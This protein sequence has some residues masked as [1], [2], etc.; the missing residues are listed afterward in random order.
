MFPYKCKNAKAEIKGS[1]KYSSIRGLVLF[2]E[3][4]KGILVTANIEGLPKSQGRCK[5]NFFG[6]H[7]HTGTLCTGNKEDEFDD[8]LTHYNPNDCIHPYH[9]GD[10]PQLLEND[11]NAY[12]SILVNKFK[13]SEIVGKVIII[14]DKPDD[15]TT[16]PSGNSG[17]KIACGVIKYC[18]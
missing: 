15:F 11:G 17:N 5:G 18:K 3:T 6:F 4:N 10:L 7:I 8:A 12:M 16:Q 13:L 2:K 14:H 9:A 1:S